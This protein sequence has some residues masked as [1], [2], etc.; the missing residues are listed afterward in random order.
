[1]EFDH[2]F[3]DTPFTEVFFKKKIEL[4]MAMWQLENMFPPWKIEIDQEEKYQD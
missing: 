1:M 2:V 4:S 3:Q